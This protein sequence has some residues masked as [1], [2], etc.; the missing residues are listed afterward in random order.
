MILKKKNIKFN[1]NGAF[2]LYGRSPRGRKDV[3]GGALGYT[4]DIL[5]GG[6]INFDIS[7]G[8]HNVMRTTRDAG[9]MEKSQYFRKLFYRELKQYPTRRSGTRRLAVPRI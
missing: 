4:N 3:K 5:L 8:Y 2:G 1:K 6:N 9:D 7:P